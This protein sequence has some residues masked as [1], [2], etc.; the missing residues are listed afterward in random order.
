M[1]HWTR[2]QA[3]TT[4]EVLPGTLGWLW[5]RDRPEC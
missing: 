1:D 3:P 4:T 2:A 5:G